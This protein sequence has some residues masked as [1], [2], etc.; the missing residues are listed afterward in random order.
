MKESCEANAE[1]LTFSKN[2]I[3]SKINLILYLTE[4]TSPVLN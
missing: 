3:L 1:I 2:K 4:H